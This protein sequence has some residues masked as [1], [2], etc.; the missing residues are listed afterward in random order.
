MEPAKGKWLM[1]QPPGDSQPCVL[2]AQGSPSERGGRPFKRSRPAGM[3]GGASGSVCGS[4]QCQQE[5]GKP[6]GVGL[7]GLLMS[8]Q[9]VLLPQVTWGLGF[10]HMV[11]NL[12]ENEAGSD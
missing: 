11:R 4:C 3:A 9:C 6:S 8:V 10:I 2:L 7:Q 1:R 5:E 12:W